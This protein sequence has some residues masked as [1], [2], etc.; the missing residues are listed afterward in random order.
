MNCLVTR[1]VMYKR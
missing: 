1:I